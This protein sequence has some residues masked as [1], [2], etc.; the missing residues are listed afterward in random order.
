MI[1]RKHNNWELGHT[2]VSV[3][4]ECVYNMCVILYYRSS[5]TARLG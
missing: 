2:R 5:G 3:Y 1:K 4:H